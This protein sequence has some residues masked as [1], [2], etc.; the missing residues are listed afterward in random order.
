MKLAEAEKLIQKWKAA[1]GRVDQYRKIS[2]DVIEHCDRLTIS[3]NG[4]SIVLESVEAKMLFNILNN[5]ITEKEKNYREKL[6]FELMVD[7]EV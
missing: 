6:K 2:S 1:K 4:N 7:V 5:T 3:A